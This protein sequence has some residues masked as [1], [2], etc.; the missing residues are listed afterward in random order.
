MGKVF[1]FP[2]FELDI[3]SENRYK[4]IVGIDE[5]G[6]G[7]WAGPV[8]VGGYS[9]ELSTHRVD[10]ITDSKQLSKLQRTKAYSVLY[11]HNYK[12]VS[13]SNIEIDDLGIN[14]V[15]IKAIKEIIDYFSDKQTLFIIDGSFGIDLG[16]NVMFFNKG[17]LNYYSI[18]C[19][20]ILAKVERDEYMRNISK[21]YPHYS[22]ENN[23]GYGTDFHQKSLDKFSFCSIHRKSFNPIKTLLNR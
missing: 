23:V 9:F 18:A 1:L 19:A 20:S 11:K 6:R 2:Q 12:V 5:V 21:L 14:R 3:L 7:A 8:Y 15:I 16:S 10:N 22:F 17:D 13:S 4:R